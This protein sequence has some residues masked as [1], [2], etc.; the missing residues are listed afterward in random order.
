M[1][2]FS[3]I[4]YNGSVEG[5]RKIAGYF[6]VCPNSE[7]NK[8]V[9]SVSLY[10]G[11]LNERK[12]DYEYKKHLKTWRL[13][14]KSNAKVFPGYIPKPIIEDYE[15][16]SAIVND[17]PKAA[18]TL[19]R[20]CL[21][22]ILRDFW[23]VKPDNLAVEITQLKDN[24]KIEPE[25]WDAIDAVRRVGKI[26]AHMEKDIN[27]IID[28]EPGEAE[29]LIGLIELLIEE[30]YINRH[31]RQLKLKAIKDLADNKDIKK[32]TSK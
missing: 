31:K 21:Q 6:L 27:L 11:Q 10:E 14:P 3:G 13:I 30:W 24:E 25:V 26:G 9:L 28:V 4:K 15:E 17:S 20:R 29:K 5:K 19:A 7:C 1:D 32:K 16:A 18:A 23:K 2:F 22:G 8:F 12:T